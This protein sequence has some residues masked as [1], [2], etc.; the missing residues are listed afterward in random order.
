MPR[1][2]SRASVVRVFRPRSSVSAQA[3][4]LLRPSHVHMFLLCSVHA[5]RGRPLLLPLRRRPDRLSTLYAK[6]R[7]SPRPPRS[8]IRRGNPDDG[9]PRP[10]R[11]RLRHLGR[12]PPRSPA[13]WRLLRRPR[14]SCPAPRQA[15]RRHAASPRRQRRQL[16][17]R[18]AP[19]KSAFASSQTSNG[20]QASPR[21]GNLKL[22]RNTVRKVLRSDYTSFSYERRVKPR[23]KLGRWKEELDRAL[24]P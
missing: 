21:I 9:A 7:L 19:K 24:R 8:Q 23:P 11:R 10:S 20:R 18:G 4:R 13:L 5:W 1:R 22:S 12:P 17:A 2:L 6:G 16:T 3:S 14:L 15:N